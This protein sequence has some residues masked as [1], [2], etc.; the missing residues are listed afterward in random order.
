MEAQA[1]HSRVHVYLNTQQLRM[2]TYTHPR[3]RYKHKRMHAYRRAWPRSYSKTTYAYTC[4]DSF[5][6][7]Q[8]HTYMHM[9]RRAHIHAYNNTIV[10]ALSH[11]STVFVHACAHAH[12]R[13]ATCCTRYAIGDVDM[14]YAL[15]SMQYAHRLASACEH[16][17]DALL[18]ACMCTEEVRSLRRTPRRSS[19]TQCVCS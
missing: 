12:M 10:H 15:C 13:H 14:R 4:I 11:T 7:K 18:L 19:Q 5:I 3:I 1:A 8:K 17:A 6:H 16:R 2:P 9:H